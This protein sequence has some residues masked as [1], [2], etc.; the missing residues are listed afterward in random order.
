MTIPVKRLPVLFLV[1]ACALVATLG[2]AQLA[3]AGATPTRAQEPRSPAEMD[4]MT[5][6]L[7]SS[8]PHSFY[9]PGPRP[10]DRTVFFNNQGP[11]GQ[12][13]ISATATFST[14]E[15]ISYFLGAPAFGMT[16]TLVTTAPW[17]VTYSIKVSDSLQPGVTFAAVTTSGLVTTRAITFTPDLTTPFISLL[18]VP[19]Y[20]NGPFTVR[21]TS[22]DTGSGVARTRLWYQPPATT[23][24][25]PAGP[26]IPG[27]GGGLYFAPSHGEGAYWFSVESKDR[28]GN[29]HPGRTVSDSRQTIYDV[30]APQAVIT[31]PAGSGKTTLADLLVGLRFA[32]T[33]SVEVF[34]ELLK[35]RR[36]RVIRRVRRR[37]GGVGGP[38]GLLPLLTV[39]ENITLPLVIGAV[40]KKIQRDKL[41]KAL[42]EFSLL[43]QAGHYPGKL[44]R[45]ENTMAQLARASVANQPLLIID[46][47]LAGLDTRTYRRVMEYLT[48][49]AL[50]GRSMVILTSDIPPREFPETDY[51]EIVNG[52][53]S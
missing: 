4:V 7:S 12:Q 45:V 24:W 13:V 23:T 46:E 39:A 42:T 37:I 40:R 27:V 49:V 38:F 34:G 14:S 3:R 47:P 30:S 35:A 9:D 16:P 36:R 5:L 48:K 25:Q 2:V 31:G 6:T 32:D 53:L 22:D 41:L 43:K 52:A 10:V 29:L 44:T 33:G 17:M 1:T 28:V 19:D 15:P 51:Y 50:S 20:G 26:S 8:R 18:D 11:Q 21:Y